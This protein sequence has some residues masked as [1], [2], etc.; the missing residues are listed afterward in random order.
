[1][2]PREKEL[3]NVIKDLAYAVDAYLLFEVSPKPWP[4]WKRKER[5]RDLK[6]KT[7]EALDVAQWEDNKE[8]NDEKTNL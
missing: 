7:K 8:R 4:V 6:L 1:M 3:V 2:T 5:R